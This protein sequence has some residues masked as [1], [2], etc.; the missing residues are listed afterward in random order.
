MALHFKFL[1]RWISPD[2][3]EQD[4]KRMFAAN[5]FKWLDMVGKDLANG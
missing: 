5:F 3:N 2:L 1:G 4:V